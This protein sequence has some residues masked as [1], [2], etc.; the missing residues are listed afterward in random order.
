MNSRTKRTALAL[1]GALVLAWGAYA[2]GTQVGGGSAVAGDRLAAGDETRGKGGARFESLADRLGVSEE[3]LRAALQ[4][5]RPDLKDERHE[6]LAALLAKELGISADKVTA[7]LER[8]HEEKRTELADA[9]AAELGID[10]AKVRAALGDKPR[11]IGAIAKELGV[12]EAQLKAA[13]RDARPEKPFRGRGFRRGGRL[14]DLAEALGVSDARLREAFSNIRDELHAD[15][16]A[17]KDRFAAQL[18][19]KL[20]I[21]QAKVEEALRDMPHHGRRGHP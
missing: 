1:T 14:D 7:A 13:L 12:T 18:A 19:Q 9:L 8:K 6:E 21:S 20:G 11:D 5:L 15:R 2:L 17:R 3:R 10:R 16:E 4:D